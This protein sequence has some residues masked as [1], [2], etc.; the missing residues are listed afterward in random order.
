MWA[1]RPACYD[2]DM[3]ID[4]RKKVVLQ[5]DL[6][7]REQKESSRRSEDAF[8]PRDYSLNRCK[9][10]HHESPRHILP[11][12]KLSPFMSEQYGV[13][14]SLVSPEENRCQDLRPG[15]RGTLETA[16][17]KLHFNS[18]LKRSSESG[19]EERC[20]SIDA[21]LENKKE[22]SVKEKSPVRSSSCP[23]L[24]EI[25]ALKPPKC[26]QPAN[27]H[28]II[29]EVEVYDHQ[30]DRMPIKYSNSIR[31][32]QVQDEYHETSP[33][34]GGARKRK[35]FT[36]IYGDRIPSP[37]K[38]PE[39]HPYEEYYSHPEVLRQQLHQHSRSPYLLHVYDYYQQLVQRLREHST[40][41]LRMHVPD[42][43][44]PT[45][46]DMQ[47]DAQ[48]KRPCRAL[49]GKHVKQ[50]TGASIST[51][52]T[53]RQKIQ[54]RQ[55]AKEDQPRNLLNVSKKMCPLKKNTPKKSKQTSKTSLN[56]IS[57]F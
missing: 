38:S 4:L 42:S 47:L 43:P 44:T 54:E 18:Q 35:S 53:L 7:E 31:Y 1:L 50:G 52:L 27:H 23:N 48:R 13:R 46:E 28:D 26:H 5:R 17:R 11:V 14:C 30:T 51:L 56:K 20:R 49:T 40:T 36:P 57:N 45:E 8:E 24:L 3:P 16:I 15:N 6:E 33:V 32:S 9:D 25:I 22:N 19:K 34:I 12:R 2:N 29:R 37:R 10:R 55:K 41:N 39:H 21:L